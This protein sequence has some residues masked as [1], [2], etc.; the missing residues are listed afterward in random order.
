MESKGAKCLSIKWEDLTSA[1]SR[2]GASPVQLHTCAL[3]LH[4][5][6]EAQPSPGQSL[7]GPG[8]PKFQPT[9]RLAPASP[10]SNP[11]FVMNVDVCL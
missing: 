4:T 6:P 1:P 11:R 10:A 5:T 9:D 2:G 3:C 8:P 7:A